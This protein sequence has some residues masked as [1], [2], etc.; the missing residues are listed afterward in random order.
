M[1]VFALTW[2]S[3][4]LVVVDIVIAYVSVAV[5]DMVMQMRPRGYFHEVTTLNRVNP[6]PLAALIQSME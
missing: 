2:T 4:P 3:Q 1:T 6:G 5:A